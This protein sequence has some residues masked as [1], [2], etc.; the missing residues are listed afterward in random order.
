MIL[1]NSTRFNNGMETTAGHFTNKFDGQNIDTIDNHTT[2]SK[3]KKLRNNGT[4]YVFPIFSQCLMS[5]KHRPRPNKQG[6]SHHNHQH[7]MRKN[8]TPAMQG[9]SCAVARGQ[10]GCNPGTFFTA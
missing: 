6:R 3:R 5:F 10:K 8:C 9:W 2:L 4:I 7:Q 1:V